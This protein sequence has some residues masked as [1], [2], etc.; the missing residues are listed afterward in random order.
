MLPPRPST[1]RGGRPRDAQIDTAVL[2]ATL[3]T[4][5]ETGYGRF[6][7]CDLTDGNAR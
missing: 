5:D 7:P 3:A 1:A 4:L 2:E 6:T